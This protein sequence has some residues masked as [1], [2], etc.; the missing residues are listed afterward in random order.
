MF[1][2]LIPLFFFFVF[3]FYNAGENPTVIPFEKNCKGHV[4]KN[5]P[6][7]LFSKSIKPEDQEVQ[8]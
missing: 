6:L 3:L 1:F 8:K 5:M 4:V 7:I 2:I